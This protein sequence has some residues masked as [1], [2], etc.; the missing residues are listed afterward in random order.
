MN[1]CAGLVWHL[2]REYR[3]DWDFAVDGREA[4]FRNDL[5][6]ALPSR[7]YSVPDRG[8][9]LRRPE[10]TELT[11][12]DAVIIDER[13]G[14]IVL[15]QL[16][17]PDIYGRSLAQRNSRRINLVKANEW[18]GRVSDWV[19]GRSSA[20]VARA[21]GLNASGK[22]APRLLVLARHIAK[23]TGETGYDPRALWGSWPSLARM[24]ER[25]PHRSVLKM[26][27][28]AEDERGGGRSRWSGTTIRRLPNLTVEVRCS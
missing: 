5:R 11:D 2:K 26:L 20:E 7:R 14:E 6:M 9:S 16:K 17:W 23:F 18:V 12:V 21:F 15:V 27:D 28:E 13:T 22:E 1:P 4:I 10:G 8:F 3:R 24:C 25:F 19:G